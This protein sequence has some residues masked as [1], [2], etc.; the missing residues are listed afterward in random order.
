M[1]KKIQLV[2]IKKGKRETERETEREREERGEDVYREE[3]R[4]AKRPWVRM[5]NLQLQLKKAYSPFH[6]ALA[7]YSDNS[8]CLR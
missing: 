3:R 6:S 7:S 4:G 8:A 2:C 5:G 1:R